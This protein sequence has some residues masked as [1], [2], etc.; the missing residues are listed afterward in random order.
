[1]IDYE[2]KIILDTIYRKIDEI[3][4]TIQNNFQRYNLIQI[5]NL[6]LKLEQEIK[7]S[8][9]LDDSLLKF[10]KYNFR[11]ISDLKKFS[12]SKLN[13][14]V[15]KTKRADIE[16][17][18]STISTS[19]NLNIEELKKL[20]GKSVILTQKSTKIVRRKTPAKTQKLKIK[21][22]TARWLSLTTEKLKNELNNLTIYPGTTSLKQS[23]DSILKPNEKRMRS[24]AKIINAIIHRILE[25]KAIAHLGR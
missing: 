25:E 5:Q 1:M 24:R 2:V 4:S 19:K 11:T 14:L 13:H 12:N 8:V 3:K 7:L 18:L 20:S 15:K 22:Q 6:L 16:K 17:E 10:F 21:D 9:K 23:A